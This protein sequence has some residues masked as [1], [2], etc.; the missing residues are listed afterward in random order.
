MPKSHSTPPKSRKPKSSGKTSVGHL[1]SLEVCADYWF[2]QDDLAPPSHLRPEAIAVLQQVAVSFIEAAFNP[3]FA[4][5]SKDIRMERPK[6]QPSDNLRFMFLARFFLEFFLLLRAEEHARGI[7]GASEHG[8]DFDLVTEMAEPLEIAF[9]TRRMK[10]ALE[11]KPPNWKELHAAV[12][13]FV[14]IVRLCYLSPCSQQRANERVD[15]KAVADRRYGRER[16]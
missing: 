2:V 13:C 4:S 12:E 8:H 14:Q 9:V 5:V 15:D 10:I 11:D 6:V 1:V 3:F 7:D 16:R